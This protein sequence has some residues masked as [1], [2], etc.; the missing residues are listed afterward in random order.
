MTCW[1]RWGQQK[2]SLRGSPIHS[3]SPGPPHEGAR[4][5]ISHKHNPGPRHLSP[6]PP[7]LKQ[8]HRENTLRIPTDNQTHQIPIDH[9]PPPSFGPEAPRWGE[10]KG[11]R[12]GRRVPD[13]PLIPPWTIGSHSVV[14]TGRL[15]MCHSRLLCRPTSLTHAL[16]CDRKH[17]IALTVI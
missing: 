2:G 6:P 10:W 9:K 15:L 5:P 8:T 11:G 13:D 16:P 1:D 4:H 17:K 14:S 3:G 12:P 7:S